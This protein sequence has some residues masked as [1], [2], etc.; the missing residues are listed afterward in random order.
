MEN[1]KSRLD[2]C[3]RNTECLVRIVLRFLTMGQLAV[4]GIINRTKTLENAVYHPQRSFHLE[5]RL[6]TQTTRSVYPIIRVTFAAAGKQRFFSKWREDKVDVVLKCARIWTAF[7]VY[8]LH[9][10]RARLRC[11]SSRP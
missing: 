11:R 9:C 10:F 5:E 4:E 1:A 7:G 3:V 8:I 2:N 6:A